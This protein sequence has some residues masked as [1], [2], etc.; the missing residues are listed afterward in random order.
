M[1]SLVPLLAPDLRLAVIG[2]GALGSELCRLLAE[3]GQ[4]RV[5]V[6]D[7]DRLEAHN[8][9]LSRLFQQAARHGTVLGKHKAD[10]VVQH[11]ARSAGGANWHALNA[12]VADVGLA[13]LRACDILISC[14]D[15]TLARLETAFAARLL[16]LPMLDGG[17][18]AQ[19]GLP[20]F[21]QQGR[22]AWFPPSAQAACQLCALSE[23]RRAELLAYALS[24]SLG[25]AAPA[26]FSPM[27]GTPA[28]VEAVA[29]AMLRRLTL[30]LNQSGQPGANS[31]SSAQIVS[32]APEP[33]QTIRL[34]Q[35]PGC[36]WHD[37][38]DPTTLV[39]LAAKQPFSTFFASIPA[40]SFLEFPW[41]ICMR[42][43][44]RQCG[45]ESYPLRRTAYTRRRAHCLHCMAAGTLEPL[46][47]VNALW[48]GHPLADRTPEQL[49]Q[50]ASQLY[51]LR[52]FVRLK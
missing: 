39:S 52:S 51:P 34:S 5:L 23:A 41:P 35:S 44:C 43:L 26:E 27:S 2:C 24:P 8:L 4:P 16:A 48:Q 28:I 20:E 12:E 29:A 11:A 42:A 49:G 25:C 13:D 14:T 32:T 7:P 1:Q 38:A 36:P 22:V 6:V 47:T 31:A 17:I 33:G 18:R 30:E 3:A 45:A 50:P 46:D 15:S 40:D 10:L 9:D 19:A 37:F 21:G